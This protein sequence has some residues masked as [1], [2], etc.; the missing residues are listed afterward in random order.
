VL[1]FPTTG[2]EEVNN[3][4]NLNPP[5]DQA[6]QPQQQEQKQEKQAWSGKQTAQRQRQRY[7]KISRADNRNPWDDPHL[8]PRYQC[9]GMEN[10]KV[11]PTKTNSHG[12]QIIPVILI[13][14]HMFHSTRLYT[15]PHA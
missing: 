3:T 6:H 7:R 14:T 15:K 12:A 10:L 5:K 4:S 2:E 11:C 8:E 1:T 9:R 13:S